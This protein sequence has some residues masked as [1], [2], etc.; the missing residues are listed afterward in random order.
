MSKL[1][2]FQ[3]IQKIK[4]YNI[5]NTHLKGG[6]EMKR[7]LSVF[8]ALLF[9]ISLVGFASAAEEA[10]SMATP[11]P[12]KKHHRHMTHKK[13]APAPAATPAAAPETK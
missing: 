12:V 2:Y 1:S 4:W 6:K 13:K 11:A 8:L 5:L 7:I 9:A 3:R 10:G